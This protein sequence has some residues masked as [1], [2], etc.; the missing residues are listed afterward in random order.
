VSNGFDVTAVF[1]NNDEFASSVSAR[2]DIKATISTASSVTATIIT[3]APGTNGIDGVDGVVQSIIAGANIAVDDSDPAN[4]VVS[5]SGAVQSVNGDTGTVVLDADDLSDTSTT[6]KFVTSAEKTKLSNLSG[7]NTGDETTATIKTKLGIT[8]LS[9]SNTGDQDLSGLVTKTTTVNG[10]ALS[11]NVTVTADDVLPAQ[12]SASGQ[13]LT[14]NG[15]TA[16]W[17]TVPVNDANWSGTS[18][19]VNHGGTGRST[20]TSNMVLVGNGTSAVSIS[21]AAPTGVFVGTTDTQTLTNKTLTSPA[22]TTPTGLTKSDVGLSNVANVDQQNASNLTSGTVA[23]ARLGTGSG[24]SVKFLRED[25]TWQ[26]IG[27]GGDA[28]TANPLSQFAPTTSA[29]LAGVMSDE[30]GSGAL[31]FATSPALVTPNLGTPS[32]ATL[33]NATGLPVSGITASTVTALGVGSLELGH[34]SD[35]TL[36]RSA[37][38]TLAVEGVDVVTTSGTQTLTNKTITTPTIAQIN[39]SSAPGVKLQVRTQT[40]NS[41]SI[42]SATTAGVFVQ[43]GY[44][45]KLGTAA[46][47]MSETVTFPT[48]FT[49]PMGVNLSF[50]GTVATTAAASASGFTSSYTSAATTGFVLDASSISTT[51]FTVN[52][53]RTSGS[54]GNTTYYAYSWIAW[55]I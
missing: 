41:D 45:Q 16:S 5:S 4:P 23:P 25:N 48:A 1:G 31:V 47:T 34:A 7:T 32:A 3:G 10:H 19:A 17:G 50:M 12:G 43:Y 36:T 21:K 28:L 39:N 18:L 14:T 38:G 20:L 46:G 11:S 49:T 52:W 8:T 26:T 55:G 2:T 53:N 22:I 33:T 37:A 44:G 35:T 30:T 27:G 54:F 6:H 42:S 40:D 9:G 29:Q 24:G 51:G 15:T 13:F